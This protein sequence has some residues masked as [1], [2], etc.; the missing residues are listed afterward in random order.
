MT[1]EAT[2]DSNSHSREHTQV[3]CR[4]SMNIRS[5]RGVLE[6]KLYKGTI[7]RKLCCLKSPYGNNSQFGAKILNKNCSF[8]NALLQKRFIFYCLKKVSTVAKCVYLNKTNKS[9]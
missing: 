6:K 3:F 7:K 4:K 5:P 9:K 1:A 2:P 8:F